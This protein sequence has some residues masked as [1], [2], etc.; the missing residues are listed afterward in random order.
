MFTLL[1]VSSER[2][3]EEVAAN[4]PAPFALP[5]LNSEG[6]PT[7]KCVPIP[8][9][10]LRARRLPRPGRG[11]RIHPER[12]GAFSSPNVD[13]LDAASTVSPLFATHTKNTRGGGT[14]QSSP[15]NSSPNPSLFNCFFPNLSSFNVQ[16]STVDRPSVHRPY[17]YQ[18]TAFRLPLF[19]Y[20]YAL[21]CTVKNDISN[22]FI[23]FHTLH[24]KHRGWCTLPVVSLSQLF[25]LTIHYSPL[26]SSPLKP[27]PPMAHPY[28]CTCK[29]GP[30]AREPRY[31]PC[32]AS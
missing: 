2:R 26:T 19:S 10:A 14:S 21:F 29:K 20:C 8:F 28:T 4:L 17:Q 18:S 27:L 5:A 15:K 22:R 12:L 9:S 6:A 30:A 7:S 31:S 1:A 3:N 23:S 11:V 16:L 24:A 25:L 32:A 13:A